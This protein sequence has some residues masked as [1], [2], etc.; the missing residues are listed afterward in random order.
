MA[1]QHTKKNQPEFK[2]LAAPGAM[3]VRVECVFPVKDAGAMTDNINAALE[4]LRSLGAAEVTQQ[5]MLAHTQEEAEAILK[6]RS[7][8]FGG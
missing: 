5:A 7:F 8:N 3:L 2:I 1:N 6:Q 4:N